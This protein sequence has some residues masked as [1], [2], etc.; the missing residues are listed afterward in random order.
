ME[1][2]I[3]CQGLE[4]DDSAYEKFL[5]T[6]PNST[7]EQTA[8]YA[9][10]LKKTYGY[11]VQRVAIRNGP[12][13]IGYFS[14]AFKERFHKKN[15]SVI[16]LPHTST[17]GYIGDRRNSGLVDNAILDYLKANSIIRGELRQSLNQA[18]KRGDVIRIL[19][20][21]IPRNLLFDSFKPAI[22]KKIRKAEK[23]SAIEV[24]T[25][26]YLSEWYSLYAKNLKSM[27][28]PPHPIS[29][30]KAYLEE[31]EGCAKLIA[32]VIN[33]TVIAG[34]IITFTKNQTELVMSASNEFA[35]SNQV[36][37]LLYWRTIE[38]AYEFGSRKVSFGRSSYGSS[39]DEYKA[40]WG[41]EPFQLEY[42]K[43]DVSSRTVTNEYQSSAKQGL[44]VYAA[45]L[46]GFVPVGTFMTE[47]CIPKLRFLIP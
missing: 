39:G 36:N 11:E 22:R 12:E 15:A 6:H 2:S 23:L 27:G 25:G 44:W 19:D 26:D 24:H 45:K 35:K 20:L 14:Y 33:E 18:G 47:K 7:F 41:A 4:Q 5:L 8:A 3:S 17:A 46:M 34:G 28:T 40:Q 43:F 29:F 42:R 9:R 37:M 13:I 38:A 31:G 32:Y 16:S 30:W 21:S 10:I 1:N